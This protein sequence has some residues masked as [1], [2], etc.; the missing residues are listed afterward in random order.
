ML[1][2]I[3]S[4]K[5]KSGRATPTASR[6][7]CKMTASKRETYKL[8]VYL[9]M[10]ICMYIHICIYLASCSCG[11][12]PILRLTD[13][14]PVPCTLPPHLPTRTSQVNALCAFRARASSKHFHFPTTS[15]NACNTRNAYI[16][17]YFAKQFFLLACQINEKATQQQLG[18]VGK[19]WQ[20]FNVDSCASKRWHSVA[21]AEKILHNANCLEKV[22]LKFY[23]NFS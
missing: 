2:F 16:R 8:T 17:T 5:Q 15:S 14:M 3:Y 18:T 4:R 10:F 6:S 11:L 22:I 19:K 12:A 1:L 13:Y 20:Y 7:A 21:V 23:N 9:Y